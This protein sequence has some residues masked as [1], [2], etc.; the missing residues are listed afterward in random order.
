MDHSKDNPSEADL[1]KGLGAI[2]EPPCS[3]ESTWGSQD[4]TLNS[5]VGRPIV[6]EEDS[7]EDSDLSSSLLQIN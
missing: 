5:Q 6:I 4:E 7:D 1:E 3:P 2:T